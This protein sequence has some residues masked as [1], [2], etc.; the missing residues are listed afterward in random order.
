MKYTVVFEVQKHAFTH[1]I[2]A[3]IEVYSNYHKDI[4]IPIWF[5][6]LI[7]NPVCNCQG[8][9]HDADHVYDNYMNP[10]CYIQKYVIYYRLIGFLKII[11]YFFINEWN[12]QYLKCYDEMKFEN[13]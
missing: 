3:H 6:R 12:R 1:C 8:F 2:F 9:Q 7:I 13:R 5:L 4:S 10:M 11:A